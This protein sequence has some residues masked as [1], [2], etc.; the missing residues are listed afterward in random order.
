MVSWV[1]PLMTNRIEISSR[2]GEISQ[3]HSSSTLSG[4]GCP[5]ISQMKFRT[6][7]KGSEQ[8]WPN[9]AGCCWLNQHV[10]AKADGIGIN[11]TLFF[12]LKKIFDIVYVYGI[13]GKG[14]CVMTHLWRSKDTLVNSVLSLHHVGPR[15]WTQVVSLG[16]RC[17]CLLSRLLTFHI[18]FWRFIYFYVCEYVPHCAWFP[19]WAIN[20]IGAPGVG[21][22]GGC[23][24][25]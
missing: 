24:L 23:D 17:L 3:K 18:C 1:S 11:F 14:A 9:W 20:G 25:F 13:W 8:P 5:L 12:K 21:V 19:Q 10:S 7:F 2:A 6:L 16:G 4:F 15:Y 22:T